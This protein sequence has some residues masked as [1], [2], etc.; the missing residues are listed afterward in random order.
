MKNEDV[1]AYSPFLFSVKENS[2]YEGIITV[3]NQSFLLSS[4]KSTGDDSQSLHASRQLA[5]ALGI[6]MGT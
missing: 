1:Y 6:V 2:S 4:V 5:L 3:E